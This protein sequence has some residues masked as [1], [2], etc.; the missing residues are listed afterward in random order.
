MKVEA[1]Q[2]CSHKAVNGN[3]PIGIGYS[4]VGSAGPAGTCK[5]KRVNRDGP[6][7]EPM[8]VT[9]CP[10]WKRVSRGAG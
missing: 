5:V 9:F 7:S 3:L 4:S 6:W 10:Y 2:L 8:C 1:Q